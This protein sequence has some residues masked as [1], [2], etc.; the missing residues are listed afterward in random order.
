MLSEGL[1]LKQIGE[2]KKICIATVE[3]TVHRIREIFNAPNDVKLI[4]ELVEREI[5]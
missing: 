3:K 5:I 4:K 1:T 2:K